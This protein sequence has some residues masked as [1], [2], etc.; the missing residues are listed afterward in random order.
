MLKNKKIT[1]LL[2]AL[3]SLIWGLV[4][5][6]IYSKFGGE[7]QVQKNL[8]Q[9]FVTVEKEQSDSIFTLS[10]DYPDPFLKGMG[11]QPENSILT[12]IIKTVNPQVFN[13]LLIEYRGFLTSNGK[14]GSTGLLKVQSSNLLVKQGMVYSAIKIR[15]ITKDSILLEYQKK[16]RWLPIFKK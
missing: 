10:L 4:F 6:K 2:I 5:Y 16:C 1:Y 13:W 3:V 8:P 9:S 12:D 7:N 15:T 14:N 11:Q